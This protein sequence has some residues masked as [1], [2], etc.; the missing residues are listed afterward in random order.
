MTDSDFM[1]GF[2]EEAASLNLPRNR[3]DPMSNEMSTSL[4]PIF[5][6]FSSDKECFGQPGKVEKVAKVLVSLT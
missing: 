6:H 3:A 2:D 1:G 5:E 4:H